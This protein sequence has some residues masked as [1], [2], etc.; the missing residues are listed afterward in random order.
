MPYQIVLHN[1][2]QRVIVVEFPDGVKTTIEAGSMAEFVF[3]EPFMRVGVIVDS[4]RH[5]Y[6][7]RYPP[8]ELMDESRSPRRFAVSMGS[9]GAIYAEKILRTGEVQSVP[10]QPDGFPLQPKR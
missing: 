8:K 4:V 1:R 5:S 6:A 3:N 2:S 7:W 10:K 9:D